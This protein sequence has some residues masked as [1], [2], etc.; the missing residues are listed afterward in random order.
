VHVLLCEHIHAA[1]KLLTKQLRL[2][3][4][5]EFLTTME[6]LVQREHSLVQFLEV[7]VPFPRH[8]L[9]KLYIAKKS[10]NAT[11]SRNASQ[12]KV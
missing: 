8:T 12:C 3:K 4:R 1:N 7:I 11:A 6:C 5:R 9:Q 10:S 2:H